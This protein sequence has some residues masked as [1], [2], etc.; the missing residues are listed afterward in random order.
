MC[1]RSQ[2]SQAKAFD[3]AN[4]VLSQE[5]Q[6]RKRIATTNYHRYSA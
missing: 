1:H 6:A 4:F 2:L 5:N 3:T